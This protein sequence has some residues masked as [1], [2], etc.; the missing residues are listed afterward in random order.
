M[1]V[2][3][4]NMH[5]PGKP[6]HF[7]PGLS[8]N[9]VRS[10]RISKSLVFGFGGGGGGTSNTFREGELPAVYYVTNNQLGTEVT[11]DCLL[12]KSSAAELISGR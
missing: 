8:K 7:H 5:Y 1:C 4:H 9:S 2:C 6:F 12:I 10:P 3:L 11:S